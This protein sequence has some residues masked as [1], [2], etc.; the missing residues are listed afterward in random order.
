MNKDEQKLAI[1]TAAKRLARKHGAANLTR[2]ELCDEAGV[3]D[4]SFSYVMGCTFSEYVTTL[5]QAQ[6]DSGKSKALRNR[7]NPAD[8]KKQILEAALL[9]A[10]KRGFNNVKRKE[11]ADRANV[12]EALV[13]HH[14]G[15]MVKLKRAVMR[16]AC[17]QEIVEIVAQ[18]LA[19][20]DSQA[21]KASP[22][23][24]KSAI[25]YLSNL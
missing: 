2:S 24:K 12:S 14:F 18:G 3:A 4:G 23:L 6:G 17:A 8:R 16:A 25:N 19:I 22:T 11:I 21:K 7:A 5:V 20:G 1:E 9:V 15:T 13:Q 10:K